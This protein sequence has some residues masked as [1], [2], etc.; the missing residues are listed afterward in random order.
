MGNITVDNSTIVFIITILL[1][2]AA[3]ITSY[4]SF[5][6]DKDK[7]ENKNKST[8][9]ILRRKKIIDRVSLSLIFLILISSIWK[10]FLDRAE[11][12]DAEKVQAEKD[13]RGEWAERQ[14]ESI[15][16]KRALAQQ[17]A[18]EGLKLGNS[19]QQEALKRVEQSL[20]SIGLKLNTKTG[21]VTKKAVTNT[22]IKYYPTPSPKSTLVPSTITRRPP[23]EDKVLTTDFAEALREEGV[24]TDMAS[25]EV[26]DKSN[27]KLCFG[28]YQFINKFNEPLILYSIY[29][30]GHHYEEEIL[31]SPNG[32]NTTPPI[33]AGFYSF[34]STD[35]EPSG[36]A[37]QFF[38]KTADERKFG[39]ISL[40]PRVGKI[41]TKVLTPNNFRLATNG[42]R[43]D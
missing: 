6:K 13:R 10:E 9:E 35:C 14:K 2:G 41:K 24:E 16:E 37:Y 39:V 43:R 25:Y 40:V 26:R 36:T 20:D 3:A 29:S 18:N 19:Q 28:E 34:S 17:A 22:I 23:V 42:K 7:E 8:A 38:F 12:K 27:L 4:I 5:V 33:Q 11:K 15:Q 32:R 1:L 31:I 21:E 30:G